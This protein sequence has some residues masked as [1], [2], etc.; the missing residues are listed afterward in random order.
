MLRDGLL[1][2]LGISDNGSMYSESVAEMLC[3]VV[4]EYHH[5][6]VQTS[7]HVRSIFAVIVVIED[8]HT[9]YLNDSDISIVI[10]FVDCDIVKVMQKYINMLLYAFP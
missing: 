9:S 6:Y 3:G 7:F 8:V 2:L 5:V 1:C 10:Y 4:I